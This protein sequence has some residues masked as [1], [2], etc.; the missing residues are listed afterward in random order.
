MSDKKQKPLDAKSIDTVIREGFLESAGR[1][2]DE[3]KRK[4]EADNPVLYREL[5]EYARQRRE[6]REAL[7]D[8]DTPTSGN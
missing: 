2:L 1:S 6:Q 4:L 5:E 8:G 7:A 3:F